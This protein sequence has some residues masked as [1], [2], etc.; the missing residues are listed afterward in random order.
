VKFKQQPS[1]TIKN[2]RYMFNIVQLAAIIKIK[3]YFIKRGG[4]RAGT[5]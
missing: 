3:K 4:R 2:K 1:S 5:L